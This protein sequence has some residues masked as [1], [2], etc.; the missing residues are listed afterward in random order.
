VIHL[1]EERPGASI[2]IGMS[3]TN[4]Q[5]RGG[6]SSS[7]SLSADVQL[8]AELRAAPLQRARL[9]VL[10]AAR[11]EM[12]H[13][14]SVLRG[15]V[16]GAV[17]EGGWIRLQSALKAAVAWTDVRD[18]HQA[19]VEHM[20][21]ACFRTTAAADTASSASSAASSSASASRPSPSSL[22][23][24]AI[25]KILLCVLSFRR[26]LERT[27]LASP[28][29]P[30]EWDVLA[31]AQAS[32][33]NYALFLQRLL[34]HQ[35]DGDVLL[36][37]ARDG[38]RPAAGSDTIHRAHHITAKQLLIRIDFN[39]FYARIDAEAATRNNNKQQQW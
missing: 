26:A 35:S 19:Y 34:Q 30:G 31:G 23:A 37:Y 20:A 9:R 12:Q 14:V 11:A 7:L 32:F 1:G 8:D 18:A 36:H 3:L 22:V 33:R 15:Y 6:S 24:G 17:L 29:P 39:A 28:I 13:V 5:R 27:D 16:L 38:D 4:G 10:H 25:D 21:R 2:G